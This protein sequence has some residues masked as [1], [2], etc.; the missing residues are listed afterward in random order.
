MKVELT[1]EWLDRSQQ[2]PLYLS[3]VYRTSNAVIS[4]L[5]PLFN[6]VQNFSPLW[7][8]LVLGIPPTL[9]TT[10]LGEV[11]CAPRLQTLKLMEDPDWRGRFHLP[12]TPLLKYL[13][14]QVSIPF[15]SISIDWSTLTTVVAEFMM[16]EEFFDVLR[17][18]EGLDSF[19]SRLLGDSESLPTTPLMHSALRELYL[20][21]DDEEVMHPSE[22]ATMLNLVAFPSLERSG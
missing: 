20:E 16:M 3:L 17:L 7:H 19:K 14:V 18:A 15:S 2:L 11:T 10:F 6:V 9:Y 22:L 5:I 1:K 12:H 8:M 21:T 4:K 13:D